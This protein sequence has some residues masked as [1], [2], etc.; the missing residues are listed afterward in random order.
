MAKNAKSLIIS[1]QTVDGKLTVAGVFKLF[2]T[3]G[4]PLDLIIETLNEHSY[5]VDWYQ[6]VLDAKKAG[7]KT[8]RIRSAIE[9]CLTDVSCYSKDYNIHLKERLEVI[10]Y[11]NRLNQ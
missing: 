10:D 8:K 1:G 7:W 2:D 4:I 6:F 5:L 3:Y 11:G 9:A